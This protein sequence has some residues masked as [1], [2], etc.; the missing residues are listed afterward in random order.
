MRTE[1]AEPTET[2]LKLSII[3]SSECLL[4]AMISNANRKSSMESQFCLQPSVLARTLCT[5]NEQPTAAWRDK[6]QSKQGT[7]AGADGCGNVQSQDHLRWFTS[8]STPKITVRLHHDD[9]K[10]RLETS[11]EDMIQDLVLRKPR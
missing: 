9:A 2:E 7:D 11:S 1:L 5:H 6:A 4:T 10:S 3:A 8:R